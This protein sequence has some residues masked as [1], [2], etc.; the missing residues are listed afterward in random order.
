MDLV[1]IAAAQAQGLAIDPAAPRS[2]LLPRQSA[3]RTASPVPFPG[4]THDISK[5][6]I[7]AAVVAAFLG[8]TQAGAQQVTGTLG[9]PGATTTISNKQ[10]PAPDPK[11]GGVIKNDALQ[12]KV[13]RPTLSPADIRKLES[14]QAEAVDGKPLTRVQPGPQ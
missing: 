10:L 5:D 7:V 3:S 8:T 6:G 14:A 2:I 9:S 1:N 4:A 13:E 11:F 12:I